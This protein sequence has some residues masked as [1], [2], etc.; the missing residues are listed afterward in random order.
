MHKHWIVTSLCVFVV[1]IVFALWFS[2]HKLQSV[3]NPER[4]VTEHAECFLPLSCGRLYGLNEKFVI[5]TDVTTGEE[6][7]FVQGC[8]GVHLETKR[9]DSGGSE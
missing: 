6:Y 2:W 3:V 9:K 1:L 5:V 4:K 7:M 8:G